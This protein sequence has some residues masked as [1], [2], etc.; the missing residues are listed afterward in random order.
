MEGL[1]GQEVSA[2][3]GIIFDGCCAV[4]ARNRD[5]W[6]NELVGAFGLG[7]DLRI[8]DHGGR[9]IFVLERWDLGLGVG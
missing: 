6:V 3:G 7:W 5:L 2:G 1:G 8:G 9:G 4:L